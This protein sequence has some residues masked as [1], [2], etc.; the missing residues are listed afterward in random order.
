MSPKIPCSVGILTRNSAATLRRAL[1]SVK[2]FEDIVICDGG[3]SDDT[4]VIAQ[5]F[6]ARVVPQPEEAKGPD[7]RLIDFSKARQASLDAARCDWFLYIDADETISEGLRDEIARITRQAAENPVAYRV[8]LGII[9]DGRVLK[10]SS[11]F[12]GY[13]TRFFHRKGDARFVKTVHE[14][15]EFAPDVTFGT[16]QHP[17]YVYTT[18]AD[19]QTYTA[20]TAVYR[21]LMSE[22]YKHLSFLQRLF[23]ALGSLKSAFGI[24]L[25]TLLIRLRYGGRDAV[26]LSG[27]VGRM[28][29]QLL[30]ALGI[31]FPRSS[32]ERAT[33]V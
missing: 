2:D 14:H 3:S 17:W 30:T 10:Y 21:A 27:E 29:D 32:R 5:E 7:G 31:L 19:W 16:L 12:P 15:V 23:A 20:D 11:N 33:H 13:Q 24:M 6:G 25:R 1:E 26:P 28:C 18:M 8:P 22:S 4:L 9:M